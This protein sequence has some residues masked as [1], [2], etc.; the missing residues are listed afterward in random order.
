MRICFSLRGWIRFLPGYL[1]RP[2]SSCPQA[3]SASLLPLSYFCRLMIWLCHLPNRLFIKIRLALHV[4]TLLPSWIHNRTL[5]PPKPLL[6]LWD[7]ILLLSDYLW[8][9]MIEPCSSFD[10]SQM[11]VVFHPPISFVRWLMV[12]L[13]HLL[14]HLNRPT[15]GFCPSTNLFLE[16]HVKTW[17]SLA[18]H[19][20]TWLST[21]SPLKLTPPLIP[22]RRT[23]IFD[24]R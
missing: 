16:P 13:R 4:R 18:S 24:L 22:Y 20:Q 11:G 2:M 3:D 15:V 23:M 12:G 8:W 17:L 10:I 7:C 19:N 1:C 14:N 6:E 21:K 9:L 5:L